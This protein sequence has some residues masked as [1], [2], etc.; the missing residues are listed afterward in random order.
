MFKLL[1]DSEEVSLCCSPHVE[2]S[3]PPTATSTNFILSILEEEPFQITPIPLSFPD[4]RCDGRPS[5]VTQ[6]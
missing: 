4:Q 1:Q 5:K 2:S 6:C 3:C